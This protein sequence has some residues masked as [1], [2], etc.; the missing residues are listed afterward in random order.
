MNNEILLPNRC[1]DFVETG[2]LRLYSQGSTSAKSFPLDG[3]RGFCRDIV[4]HAVDSL[5]LVCDP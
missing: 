5:D 1:H 4:D 3:C 2:L